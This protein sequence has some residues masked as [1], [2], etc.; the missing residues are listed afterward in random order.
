MSF[1]QWLKTASGNAGADASIN[2]AEGMSPTA[3]NDSSRAMMARLAEFRDDQSGLLVTGGTSTA[4]TVTTNEGLNT[5]TP[6]DGQLI[7]ITMS[8]TNGIA[9]TLAADGGTAYAIQASA[10]VPVGA[11]TLI[12]GSPYTLKFSAA[13][14]AWM[15]RDF[16]GNPFNIPLGAMLPYIAATAP[17]SNFALPFG[18][19]I[20]RTTYASLFSLVGTTYGP[21]DGTTTFNIPDLRGRVAAGLGNMGGSDAG[22]LTGSYFG[23]SGTTLGSVGG[24]ESQTLD[25]TEIPAHS[26][27][28]TLNDPG[29]THTAS[30]SSDGNTSIMEANLNLGTIGPAQGRFLNYAGGSPAAFLAANHATG[31]SI[32]NN[33]NTGGGNPHPNVQPT[34]I[35][36]YILRII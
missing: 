25:A 33:N 24:L 29:H 15:L 9:P 28:N 3:V 31:M 34:I 21:G 1:W 4:Y 8:A 10:G 26:H 35:L 32:S 13:N 5:P 14:S 30:T 2:W 16:Y 17:N 6:T 36:G 22:R 19:A 27:P 20:S 12:L 18:Q 11:A 7:S 23:A